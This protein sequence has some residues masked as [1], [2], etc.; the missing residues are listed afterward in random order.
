MKSKKFTTHSAFLFWYAVRLGGLA[1]IPEDELCESVGVNP[2]LMRDD[3]G[4]VPYDVF[5]K[6]LAEVARRLGNE[7]F[8]LA[9]TKPQV[10]SLENPTWYYYYNA[11]N[12]REAAR[13]H[14]RFY[15]IYSKTVYPTYPVIGDEVS[16]RSTLRA[17]DVELSSHH[18]DLMLASWWWT[19]MHFCGPALKLKCVR[20][21]S[22][23][24][25]RK[26]AHKQ[27]LCHRSDLER[28]NVPK[29]PRP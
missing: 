2:A 14:E 22:A 5:K 26:A 20:L 27:F 15:I 12:L 17:A 28:N 29:L 23:D 18:V 7:S 1:G 13:R 11:P 4:E 21:T 3:R 19:A 6:L 9:E 24:E 8:W 10:L 25:N 16:L